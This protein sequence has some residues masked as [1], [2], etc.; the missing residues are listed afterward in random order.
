MHSRIQKIRKERGISQ[1]AFATQ[2]K[3]SRNFIGLL[4]TGQRTPSDR[5]I[6]DICREFEINEDWLR[7][8]E[9]EM[10]RKRTREEE[11]AD[12]IGKILGDN[13]KDFQRR[14]VHAL[15]RL[16]YDQWLMLEKVVDQITDDLSQK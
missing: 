14:F 11:I 2:L 9:G 4:E 8:G 1:Q 15:A 12:F 13:E 3:L 7:Y 6:G 16:D 5:T 10:H